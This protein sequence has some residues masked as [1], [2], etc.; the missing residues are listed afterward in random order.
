MA[1]GMFIPDM[2]EEDDGGVAAE[3]AP[4]LTLPVIAAPFPETEKRNFNALRR[5]LV[6]VACKDV[7]GAHYAFDS[8]VLSPLAREGFKALKGVIDRHPGSPLSI[9]GHADPEGSEIYNKFLSERRAE[10]VFGMLIRD[11][12]TWERLFSHHENTP[13]DVWGDDAVELMLASLGFVADPA[14]K[15]KLGDVIREYQRIRGFALTGRNDVALRAK[16]FA[17]YMDFLCSDANGKPY[18]LAKS[19]F[20]GEGARHGAFQ[21]CS[22]FNPRLVLAKVEEDAFKSDTVNGKA[23]RATANFDNRRCIIYFFEK[24]SRIDPAKWP[25]PRASDQ[26]RISKCIAHFWSDGNDRKGKLLDDKRRRFGKAVRNRTER[27]AQLEKTFACRFYHG[28]AL[29]SPCE[30]DLQMWVLQLLMDGPH[31]KGKDVDPVPVANVRYVV[32]AS[33]D[34]EAPVIRG[35]TSA[36]GVIGL[37]LWATKTVMRL[38]LDIFA[39]I[40]GSLPPVDPNKKTDPNKKP[41]PPID[42]EAPVPVAAD[43][44]SD[45]FKDENTFVE[46]SLVG[47]SLQRIV[48]KFPPGQEPVALEP[49]ADEPP[50]AP[51]E[52]SLGARQRLFNLGYGVENPSRWTDA[53]LTQF[54]QRFQ[55]EKKLTVTGT[56]DKDTIDRLREEYGS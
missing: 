27:I 19:D 4:K 48:P 38:K 14:Q 22:E 12:P 52:Q 24:G 30:G 45:P 15:Q 7:P 36:N 47:G 40:T 11:V 46:F 31:E 28:L 20:L 26:D 33:L 35:T 1:E 54:V 3:H 18:Q 21:G 5:S 23:D 6:T 2:V 44:L 8:S 13:G 55:K 49:D 51:D 53:Q 34:P 9:F 17:E 43:D 37:P 50:V 10:A 25:C 56:L 16:L 41:P 42:L 29:H 32:Q 39:V